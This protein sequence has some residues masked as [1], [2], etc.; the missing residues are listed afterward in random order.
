MVKVQANQ[1][2]AADDALVLKLQREVQHLKDIL[3]LNR[4]G[5]VLEVH[6]QLLVL[7]EENHRLKDIATTVHTVEKLKAENKSLRLELQQVKVQG[8]SDAFRQ[9][10][11]TPGLL[12]SSTDQGK[13]LALMSEHDA[14]VHTLD[15]SG[16]HQ[17]KQ[18]AGFFM[19]ETEDFGGVMRDRNSPLNSALKGSLMQKP[20]QQI[21]TDRNRVTNSQF[22]N[23]N[24]SNGQMGQ[25]GGGP[26]PIQQSEHDKRISEIKKKAANLKGSLA[27]NGRCPKCT[28]KPPCKHYDSLEA[29]NGASTK[30]EQTPASKQ[31]LEFY[32]NKVEYSA[33]MVSNSHHA[34]SEQP[35]F[36]KSD[37]FSVNSNRTYSQGAQG[38]VFQSSA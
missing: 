8:Y 5:G 12:D 21:A 19:T 31:N 24:Y 22:Q 11:F 34:Q 17:K 7:K 16:Y 32:P 28:L 38:G 1:V 10:G 18:E 33:S 15:D 3:N 26:N 30:E 37:G 20:A 14:Q 23:T 35:K 13:P 9:V 36:Q 6:Q 4:K 27:T 25:S 29:L 2:S